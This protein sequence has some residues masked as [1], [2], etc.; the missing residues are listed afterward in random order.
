MG[1]S[2][3][4]RAIEPSEIYVL[5]PFN[6]DEQA[7]LPRVITAAAQTIQAQLGLDSPEESTFNL[8]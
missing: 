8:L 5:K 3:N 6:P 2:L 1:I 4:D 7:A